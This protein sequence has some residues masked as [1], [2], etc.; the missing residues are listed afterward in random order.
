MIQHHTLSIPTSSRPIY[1]HLA[2]DPKF[3]VKWGKGESM[4]LELVCRT[5]VTYH[6]HSQSLAT[7]KIGSYLGQFS[8]LVQQVY[9]W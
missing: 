3:L 7:A 4:L 5:H 2:P 8:E 6:Q 9:R 1:S